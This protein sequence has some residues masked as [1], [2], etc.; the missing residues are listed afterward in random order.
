MAAR[1]LLVPHRLHDPLGTGIHRYGVELIRALAADESSAELNYAV[2][3]IDDPDV[4]VGPPVVHIAPPR[5]VLHAAWATARRPTIERLA[6]GQLG[7][8]DAPAP[9][10][11]RCPAPP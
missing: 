6:G 9:A 4:A 1:V 2:A 8:V 7:P 10:G 3:S 11:A 5:R